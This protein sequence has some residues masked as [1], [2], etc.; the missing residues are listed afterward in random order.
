MSCIVS[1]LFPKSYCLAKRS[2]RL[3]IL[4]PNLLSTPILPTNKRKIICASFHSMHFDHKSLINSIQFD[5]C[6][7]KNTLQEICHINLNE[8]KSIACHRPMYKRYMWYHTKIQTSTMKITG[9]GPEILMV[10]NAALAIAI[11]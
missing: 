4:H 11:K 6:I 5:I 9:I 2:V 8:R 1:L 3:F 10:S 7:R